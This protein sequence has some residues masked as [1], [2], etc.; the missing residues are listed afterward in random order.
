MLLN[1]IFSVLFSVGVPNISGASSASTTNYL[2][3]K[4]GYVMS[5]NGVEGRANWVGW[6]LAASDV[7]TLYHIMRKRYKEGR[8]DLLEKYSEICLRRVWKAERF[9][10]WMTSI[11]H[12]FSDDP[13][14]QRIQEAELSYYTSSIAG[15]TTIAENYV[16]LPYEVIL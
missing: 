13:F 7:Y 4:K 5:Y 2:S 12:K 11:L 3:V 10:W 14:N 16:G 15:R 6:T 1:F 9:S 8:L